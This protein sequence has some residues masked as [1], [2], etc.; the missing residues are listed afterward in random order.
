MTQPSAT[1]AGSAGHARAAATAARGAGFRWGQ[2]L[3]GIVCMAMIANL[4]FGWTLFVNPIDDKHGW[5]RAAIQ[6]AFTIFM[7]AET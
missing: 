1:I 6:V 5:S 2:L 3:M 7:L 4:Q